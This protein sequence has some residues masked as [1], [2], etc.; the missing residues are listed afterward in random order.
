MLGWLFGQYWEIGRRIQEAVGDRAAYGK[1]LLAY[2]SERLTVD[3]GPGFTERNLR[4]MRQF[5]QAFPIRHALRTELS[6]T[7]YR[8][9]MSVENE[10]RRTWYMNEAAD[11]GWSSRQLDRQ[12]QTFYYDRLLATQGDD[13]KREV[14]QEIETT[15]PVTEA[16]DIVRDPYVLEFLG[17][18]KGTAYLEKDLENALIG[19][20]QEFLLELGRGFC[21]V[22]RQMR[23]ND[24]TDDYYID[25][26]FYN[27]LTRCFVLIDLKTGKLTH[28][29]VGQMDFY[30]RLFEEKYKPAGDSPPIGIILCSQKTEATV[31]Y[32]VLADKQ[33][34]FASQYMTYLPTEEELA[35]ALRRERDEA[36]SASLWRV[37]ED[38]GSEERGE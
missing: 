12:I 24:G 18:P 19:K 20:L 4:N 2:L 16:D 6:W 38:G 1:Q 33:N 35:E 14:A 15:R 36:E 30:V 34:L 9:L 7:H 21:F 13:A 26:V 11:A 32:S 3:F 10:E 5:Y 28:Q 29:D 27:Y 37:L 25:L 22:G 31:R 23:I 8:L 17:I